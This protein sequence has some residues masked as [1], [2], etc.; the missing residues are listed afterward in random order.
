MMRKSGSG[1]RV[2]EPVVIGGTRSGWE[3]G[4]G[5]WIWKLENIRLFKW[6][7]D[8]NKSWQFTLMQFVEECDLDY[9]WL[10]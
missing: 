2:W 3:P 4:A 9:S 10:L 1:L 5:A 7:M 8:Y 6:K